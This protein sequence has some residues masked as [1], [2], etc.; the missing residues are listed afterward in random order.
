[1][2]TH[3]HVYIRG[4]AGSKIVIRTCDGAQRAEWG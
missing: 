1:M 4:V 2:A 3:K